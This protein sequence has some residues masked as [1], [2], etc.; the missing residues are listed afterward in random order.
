MVYTGDDSNKQLVNQPSPEQWNN[1]FQRN[2]VEGVKW[3]ER[4]IWTKTYI[5]KIGSGL[6][7]NQS[8][9]FSQIAAFHKYNS[10]F[11]MPMAV[12]NIAGLCVLTGLCNKTVANIIDELETMG[13]IAVSN[14]GRQETIGIF[15]LDTESDRLF[16]HSGEANNGNNGAAELAKKMNAGKPKRSVPVVKPE[17]TPVKE[18]S[19]NEDSPEDAEQRGVEL[20]DYE[21]SDDY[22]DNLGIEI[23][24]EALNDV[25]VEE[26]ESC[27]DFKPEEQNIQS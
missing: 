19:E 24:I 13:L 16:L 7:F 9:V 4:F 21:D 11:D 5:R 8:I 18:T 25:V 2:S 1:L 22:D 23:A 20:E 12:T 6:S 17:P 3:Q 26:K 14:N 10:E 27:E 15:D